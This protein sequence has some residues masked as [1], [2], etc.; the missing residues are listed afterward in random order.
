MASQN[1]SP[2][3]SHSDLIATN[4]ADRLF[5]SSLTPQHL[6]Q[7]SI[8]RRRVTIRGCKRTRSRQKQPHVNYEGAYRSPALHGRFDL[9]GQEFWAEHPLED[10]RKITL[11]KI[12][13]GTI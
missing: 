13:I 7:L 12:D 11:R 8:V 4:V 2:K 10:A 9:L 5:T 3:T 6:A 1:S